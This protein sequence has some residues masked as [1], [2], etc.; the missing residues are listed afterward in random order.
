V[1]EKLSVT[2]QNDLM[3]DT[4]VPD[5][6]DWTWVLETAC[7]ECGFEAGELEVAEVGSVIRRN[8]AEF[9]EVL[10]GPADVLRERRDPVTWS[11][12]EYGAHVRDV[13]RLYLE[14]LTMM[15]AEDDPLYPNW[16]QDE[17]A[18][19]DNYGAQDPAVVAGELV[20]AA[21]AL[22]AAFDDVHGSQWARPGR[23]GDGATFTVET[24]AR[25]LIHDPI[26]HLHDVRS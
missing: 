1:P 9:A 10:S 11:P 12:L 15:L 14:R 17:T 7:P 13:Y 8:A 21:E 4:I 19:A 18:V 20:D 25:Y 6:K 26:H 5:D 22:A 16:D 3:N 24:F 23:R 2:A